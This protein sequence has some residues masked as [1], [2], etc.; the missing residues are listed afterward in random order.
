MTGLERKPDHVAGSSLLTDS[1][2]SSLF[3]LVPLRTSISVSDNWSG[4]YAVINRD[5]SRASYLLLRESLSSFSSSLS[6]PL[7]FITFAIASSR[8]EIPPFA[9][10]S[11]VKIKDNPVRRHVNLS[12]SSF[13]ATFPLSSSLCFLHLQTRFSL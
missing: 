11:L 9:P 1:P 5:G 2:A 4:N 10:G 8:G 13:S 12:L 3:L 7:L 6:P